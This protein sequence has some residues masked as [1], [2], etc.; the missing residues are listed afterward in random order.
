MIQCVCTLQLCSYCLLVSLASACWRKTS[1]SC[2]PVKRKRKSRRCEQDCACLFVQASTGL[3]TC[4]VPQNQRKGI[5]LYV[6][7]CD[8]LSRVFSWSTSLRR[9]SSSSRRSFELKLWKKER[10]SGDKTVLS[11]LFCQTRLPQKW[12]CHQDTFLMANWGVN[13]FMTFS[14]LSWTY[15]QLSLQLRPPAPPLMHLSSRL[16]SDVA[17]VMCPRRLLSSRP[18]SLLHCSILLSA[19]GLC[20]LLESSLSLSLSLSLWTSSGNV[21]R[22]LWGKD[23]FS[24]L[25]ALW[26]NINNILMPLIINESSLDECILLFQTVEGRVESR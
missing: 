23:F 1:S 21:E 25:V 8:A 17:L 11:F 6:C 14:I 20:P 2:L 10:K 26:T 16:P 24:P 4:A 5:C 9:C 3:R 19:P 7:L 15:H 13:I 22:L 12:K 18:T